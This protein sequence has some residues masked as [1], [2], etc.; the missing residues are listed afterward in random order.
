MQLDPQ[1]ALR[2]PTYT[3]GAYRYFTVFVSHC[4]Y[5][6]TRHDCYVIN[7]NYSKMFKVEDCL[8]CPVLQ[9]QAGDDYDK[10]KNHI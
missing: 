7:K 4:T 1:M 8:L 5:V 6:H 3:G 2:K 10:A 9:E